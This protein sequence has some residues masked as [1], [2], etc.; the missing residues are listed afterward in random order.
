MTLHDDAP[1]AFSPAETR[2][3]VIQGHL[4]YRCDGEPFTT[5]EF[6][7]AV[8][9]CGVLLRYGDGVDHVSTALEVIA[10]FSAL[11]PSLQMAPR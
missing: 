1:Y 7:L 11:V 6:Y 10:F 8:S 9:D 2:P 5:T 3:R 4:G